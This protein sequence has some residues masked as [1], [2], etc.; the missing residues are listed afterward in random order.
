MNRLQKKDPYQIFKE[1]V[2]D[3]VVRLYACLASSHQSPGCKRRPCDVHGIKF[4]NAAR[5]QLAASFLPFKITCILTGTRLLSSD[6]KAH[7][8]RP[9]AHKTG[10]GH[11]PYLGQRADR[12]RDNVQ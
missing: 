8:L 2:T 9:D 1:P 12:S 3:A 5:K 7:E 11:V 4:A 10:R 6:K